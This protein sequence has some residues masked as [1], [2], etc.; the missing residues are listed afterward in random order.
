MLMF[1]AA[2]FLFVNTAQKILDK[3]PVFYADK[4]YFLAGK[5]KHSLSAKIIK[6]RGT[7]YCPADDVLEVYGFKFNSENSGKY[8]YVR[9]SKE[10]SI[11][12]ETAKLSKSR[13]RSDAPEAVLWHSKLYLSVDALDR[14]ADVSTVVKGDVAACSLYRRDTLAGT[15]ITDKYRSK[16]PMQKYAGCYIAGDRTIE[17][18]SIS[19]DGAKKY[20]QAVNAI[21]EK[22]PKVNTFSMVVPT[23][24]EFYSTKDMCTNQINGIKTVYK[25][26]SKDVMPIN[27]VDPIQK[28]LDENL[29]F[30]TDHHWTQRGAYYAY[31][32]FNDFRGRSTPALSE[33]ENV[34]AEGFVGS[35][36]SFMHGTDGE[37]ICRENPDVL[38]RFIPKT[39]PVGTAYSDMALTKPLMNVEAVNTNVVSYMAFVGG[40]CPISRF[41]TTN[42]NK[43]SILIVKESY[44]NALATWA[45]NDYETVYILDPRGFN[46]FNGNAETFKID[47]F[48]SMFPFDDLLIVNYPAAMSPRLCGAIQNLI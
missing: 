32:A 9:K 2:V 20:A 27:A 26:L 16:T 1:F 34:P 46:G 42:K 15:V 28:H 18:L 45:M 8:T 4:T 39:S 6:C 23:S 36:A 41:T 33:F 30:K 11:T 35:F 48:Y 21:A 38:E 31:R 22:L 43:K 7:V 37:K 17:L 3:S 13:E 44:G 14:L 24:S 5:N 25:N 19:S 40:D 12:D 10:I 47:K 29:Y